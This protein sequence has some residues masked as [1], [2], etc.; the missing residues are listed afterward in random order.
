MNNHRKSALRTSSGRLPYSG[1]FYLLV[2]LGP[3]NVEIVGRIGSGLRP[4]ESW[5]SCLAIRKAL[6]LAKGDSPLSATRSVWDCLLAIPRHDF[7][8]KLGEDLSIMVVARSGEK[9]VLSAVGLNSIWSITGADD[10]TLLAGSDQPDVNKL[11]VPRMAPKALE[12]EKPG[13]VFFGSISST[14]VPS[15]LEIARLLPVKKGVIVDE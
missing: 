11:G 3:L 8:P 9:G 1:E 2:E 14:E 7:G 10:C 15:G 12:F 5:E 13:S 4:E 6:N